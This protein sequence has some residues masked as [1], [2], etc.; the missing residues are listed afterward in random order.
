MKKMKFF[1][2]Y[3]MILFSIVLLIFQPASIIYYIKND[4][5]HPWE[6]L[7]NTSSQEG[8]FTDEPQEI[9][10]VYRKKTSLAPIQF[11][12][13]NSKTTVR[14]KGRNHA[15]QY[16]KLLL[17]VSGLFLFGSPRP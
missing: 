14:P 4:T 8:K 13:L 3:M 10:F 12:T 15:T 17:I 1:S 5:A 6:L 9:I 2:L 11:V 7:N 16:G